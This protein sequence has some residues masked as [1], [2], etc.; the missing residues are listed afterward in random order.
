MSS[1]ERVESALLK[2]RGRRVSRYRVPSLWLADDRPT[3]ASAVDPIEVYLAALQEI[4][5]LEPPE[6]PATHDWSRQ[7]MG[8]Q[9]PLLRAPQQKSGD[10][11]RLEEQLADALTAKVEIRV[12]RKTR[13][14]EQ[15]EVV[16]SFASLDELSGLLDRLGV[17]ER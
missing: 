6:M 15:G 14:G 12:L 13:R 1:L 11:L 4:R 8:R 5:T 10:L 7:A 17:K 2:L 3:T 9:A 16:I